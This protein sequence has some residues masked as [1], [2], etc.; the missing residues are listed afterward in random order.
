MFILFI[1]LAILFVFFFTNAAIPTNDVINVI[2]P[3]VATNCL[4]YVSYNIC[5]TI[6]IILFEFL[7]DVN[8]NIPGCNNCKFDETDTYLFGIITLCRVNFA[9]IIFFLLFFLHEII[10]NIN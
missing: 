4:P 5:L 1:S 8:A 9:E 3:C 2:N 10:S 6:L 7:L